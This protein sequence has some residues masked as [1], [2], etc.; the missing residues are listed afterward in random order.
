MAVD[1]TLVA[2]VG[3]IMGGVG[4]KLTEAWL[5]KNRVKVDDAS[6]IR[7]ELRLSITDLREDNKQLEDKLDEWRER[8]Y[9]AYERIVQLETAMKI[10]GVELPPDLPTVP[11]PKEIGP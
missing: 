5:N 7:S 8:Y 4:L 1:P 11:K 9:E 10:A 2:L 3:T 6:Q